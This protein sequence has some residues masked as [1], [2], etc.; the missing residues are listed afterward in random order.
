MN[1]FTMMAVA[2]AGASILQGIVGAKG[3]KDAAKRQMEATANGGRL[4]DEQAGR[5]EGFVDA[6]A[7]RALGYVAPYATAGTDALK[8]YRD[9]IGV[10]GRPAQQG[11]YDGFMDDPGFNAALD[12]GRQQ[13]EHS[14]IFQGRGDS[15]ATMKELFQFGE[16]ER[17]GAYERR[18]DRLS[19]LSSLGMQAGGQAASIETNR[20]RTLA[21]IALKRGGVARDTAMGIGTANAGGVTGRTNAI[22]GASGGVG[23]SL[24]VGSGRVDGGKALSSLYRPKAGNSLYTPMK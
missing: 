8:L 5:A 18:L 11:Y 7:D 19:G 10:N 23:S 17:L 21:D 14:A 22:T 16:R 2:G 1:P 24:M 12:T 9:A 4:F 20:G 13:L 15:G 6:G 3:A